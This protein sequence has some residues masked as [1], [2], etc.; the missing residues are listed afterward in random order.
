MNC[1]EKKKLEIKLLGYNSGNKNKKYDSEKKQIYI[2]LIKNDENSFKQ[3]NEI[4]NKCDV[5][6][7]NEFYTFS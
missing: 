4:D 6:N 1:S 2:K 5:N 7:E 3:T